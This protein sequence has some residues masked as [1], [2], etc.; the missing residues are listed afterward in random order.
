MENRLHGIVSLVLIA[1][2]FLIGILIIIRSNFIAGLIYAALV[3]IGA[4]FIVYAY[5]T[6]CP[7][8][9][10]GCR[11]V[12]PG[13]LTHWLPD[14]PQTA[15]TLIDY[16][17]VTLI[18]IILAVFPHPWL[19]EARGTL[20]LFWALLLAGLVEIILFVCKACGNVRCLVCKWRNKPT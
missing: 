17:T 1:G 16:L 19:F 13:L 4:V 2:A 8:R 9:T 15:Y 10:S 3:I 14:R 5:C 6:K 18:L 11:H 12:L 7:I 20:L